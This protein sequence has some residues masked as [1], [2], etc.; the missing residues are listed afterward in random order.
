MLGLPLSKGSNMG[1]PG[2]FV[3][4]WGEPSIG[5]WAG[6][7]FPKPRKLVSEEKLWISFKLLSM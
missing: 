6:L 1:F 7:S 4:S 3:L 5:T 2:H